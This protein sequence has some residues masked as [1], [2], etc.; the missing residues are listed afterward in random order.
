MTGLV[1]AVVLALLCLGGIAFAARMPLRSL[2]PVGT[3][4]MLGLA[5][6]AW[7][8][9]PELDGKPVAPGAGRPRFDEALVAKRRAIGEEF[10][11]SAKWLVISDG[12]A[13]H[14]DTALAANLLL[15]GLRESPRDVR[16]W[17]A[18]GN[19]LLMHGEGML[20]PAANYA[21]AQALAIEPQGALPNYFY[22]LALAES[23]DFENARRI[24]S[25]LAARLP[26][27]AELRAELERNDQLL[28]A[29][30]AR[31]NAAQTGTATP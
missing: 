31:R 30:I 20:S 10:G 17:T 27:Q 9:R 14:G 25:A 2:A 6:Y 29:L 23:G 16:L 26:A 12:Q 24:W 15:A 4:L 19:A 28:T 8:G 21:Y 18:L 3:A 1:I 5:G 13:R 7:Q 22:G 11:P